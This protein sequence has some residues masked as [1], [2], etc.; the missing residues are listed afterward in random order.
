MKKISSID[1]TGKVLFVDDKGT[2]TTIGTKTDCNAYGYDYNGRFCYAFKTQKDDNKDDNI[3][4]GFSTSS[5]SE[6]YSA[7]CN[8]TE[9]FAA[10]YANVVGHND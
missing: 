5:S 1:K 10:S 8:C 4:Q 9:V 3:V 7:N 6:L 2:G